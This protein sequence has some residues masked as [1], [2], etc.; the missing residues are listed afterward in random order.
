MISS[1]PLKILLVE[2][3][4]GDVQLI[5]EYLLDSGEPW[6]ELQG[7]GTLAQALEALPRLKPDVVLLDLGLPDSA[8]L[9]GPRRIL[10]R[11]PL[12][13]LVI[14][15]GLDDQE[16]AGR[17]VAEGA[18]DFLV[19]SEV[20]GGGLR[21]VIRYAVERM[22][23]WRALQESEAKYQ[24][25]YENAPEMLVS[26]DPESGTVL[27]CNAALADATGWSKGELVGKP[28]LEL[29]HP[30]SRERA[31][32]A[33]DGLN[34]SGRIMGEELEI[35]TRAGEAIH[36]SLNVSAFRDEGG[37]ILFSRSSLRDITVRKKVEEDLAA[38]MRELQCLSLSLEERVRC[39]TLELDKANRELEA[40]AYSVS[41]DLRG[42]P[43]GH[44]RVFPDSGGGVPGSPGRRGS[45]APGGGE[46]EHGANGTAYRGPPGVFPC[47][48]EGDAVPAGGHG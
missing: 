16:L 37:R 31:R 22:G 17:A 25:L 26:V 24:D 30:R 12:T 41:H 47:G 23:A 40:F 43:E 20:S 29:Y 39:R 14:L 38:S 3:N 44:R 42:A 15:T 10:A 13:P 2:D 33:F 5:R 32:E 27:E 34:K 11:S 4:P 8:G 7:V 21:R 18:Q 48:A 9:E 36:V 6:A 46:G 1:S 19:K 45:A 28:V 35:L